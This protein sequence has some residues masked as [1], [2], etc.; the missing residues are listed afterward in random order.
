MTDEELRDLIA[1]IDANVRELMAD[2]KLAAARY[3]AG[4]TG[5]STDRAAGLKALLEARAHYQA[6]LDA[7]TAAGEGE[8]SA[9]SDA[10]P[11]TPPPYWEATCYAAD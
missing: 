8:P 2:G 5:I 11:A 7:R 6:L 3:T 10:A 4:E 1:T 9:D